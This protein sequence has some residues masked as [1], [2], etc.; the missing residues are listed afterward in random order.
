MT[1]SGRYSMRNFGGTMSGLV[2]GSLVV[3]HELGQYFGLDDHEMV[4]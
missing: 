2:L 3:I 4:F 1:K